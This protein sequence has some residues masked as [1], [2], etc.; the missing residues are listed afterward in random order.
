MS[1]FSDTKCTISNRNW[2]D[3]AIRD[4]ILRQYPKLIKNVLQGRI[5]N[6]F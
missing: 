4:E 2:T 6:D 5:Q 3:I 1:A